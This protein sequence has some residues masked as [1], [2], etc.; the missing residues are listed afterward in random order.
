[1]QAVCNFSCTDRVQNPIDSVQ[2]PALE[3][4][5]RARSAGSVFTQSGTEA[6]A[7]WKCRKVAA[8]ERPVPEADSYL[9]LNVAGVTG[10]EAPCKGQP[11]LRPC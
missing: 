2:Q 6:V 8:Q 7:R 5:R 9:I 1:M 3:K 4:M 11:V 10:T